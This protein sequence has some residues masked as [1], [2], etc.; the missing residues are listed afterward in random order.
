MSSATITFNTRNAVDLSPETNQIIIFSTVIQN[1]D[2]GYDRVTGIFTSLVN[3]TF[4]FNVQVCTR[5][6]NDWAQFQLAVDRSNNII[7]TVSKYN[8][9]TGSTTTSNSVSHYL[10]KGQQVWVQSY[11]NSGSTSRLYNGDVCWNQFSGVFI[12]N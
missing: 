4:I 6:S 8:G 1:I 9:V 11:Y 7:L 2:D 10:T 12:H 3:G 5:S